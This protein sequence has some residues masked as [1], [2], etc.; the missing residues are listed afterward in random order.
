M[1]QVQFVSCPR[2]GTPVL[3]DHSICSAKYSC[4]V[5]HIIEQN[6]LAGIGICKAFKISLYP[7]CFLV[8]LW[9]TKHE[10]ISDMLN[11]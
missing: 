2:L 8:F 7:N 1:D 9:S 3:P 11:V 6:V 5:V 4:V 10:S